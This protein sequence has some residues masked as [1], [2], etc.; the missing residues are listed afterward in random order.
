M[1]RMIAESEARMEQ[2]ME[3]IMDQKVQA[4]HKRLDAFKLRVLERPAPT[5]NVSSFKTE[6]ASLQAD[7]DTFLAPPKTEHDSAPIAPIDNTVLDALFGDKMPLFTSSHHTGKRP[8][9]SRTSNDIKAGRARKRKCQELEAAG[10]VSIV[11][12]EMHQQWVMEV[13][14]GTSSSVGTTDGAMRVDVS[15]T[16]GAV[17]LDASTTECAEIVDVGT[18]NGD[19]SVDL[20]GSG[21]PYPPVC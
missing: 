11:D 3:H 14:V 9:S 5:T 18:I 4:V 7:L 21:K 12:E 17:R 19:P 6:L 20:V 8:H 1:Q 15:T 2:R 13:G 16:D 10:R